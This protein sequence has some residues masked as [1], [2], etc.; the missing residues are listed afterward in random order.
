MDIVLAPL[1]WLLALIWHV[2]AWIVSTVFW[3]VVWLLLPLAVAAALALKVAETVLGRERV[4]AVIKARAQRWGQGTWHLTRRAMFALS[5]M[6]FRV[7]FYFVIYA[8]WHALVSL[9]V[10]PRWRPW[11]RAWSKRWRPPQAPHPPRP[12]ATP[13]SKSP[14]RS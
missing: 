2:A 8:V 10:K 9:V 12:R 4:R 13:P 11:A 3:I 1:G 14:A 7:L 6:P 5:A